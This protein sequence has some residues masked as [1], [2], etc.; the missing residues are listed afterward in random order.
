MGNAKTG[1]TEGVPEDL[2][3]FRREAKKIVDRYTKAE[4]VDYLARELHAAKR[5]LMRVRA[6]QEMAERGLAELREEHEKLAVIKRAVDG[7]VKVAGKAAGDGPRD[8]RTLS[9]FPDLLMN[10]G[11]PEVMD[12][13][14]AALADVFDKSEAIC[15][16]LDEIAALVAF[17]DEAEREDFLRALGM[18]QYEWMTSRGRCRATRVVFER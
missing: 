3:V 5:R 10:D 13:S 18:T 8:A 6:A 1:K 16:R 4:I 12:G 7:L 14:A 15:E 17:E 2:A 11:A 9:L